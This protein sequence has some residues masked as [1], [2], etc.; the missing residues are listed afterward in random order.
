MKSS[1]FDPGLSKIRR[2]NHTIYCLVICQM[3]KVLT[4]YVHASPDTSL[5][6]M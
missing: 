1:M 5:K 6:V 4:I 3:E 2:V